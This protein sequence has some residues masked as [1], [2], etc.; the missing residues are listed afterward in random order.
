M[1]GME[2]TR[3]SVPSVGDEFDYARLGDERRTKRL[4]VIAERWSEAPDRSVLQASKSSAQAEGAYRFLN[5]DGFS[6]VPIVEAHAEQTYERIAHEQV[7]IV[8][9]DTTEVA[10]SGRV[11]REG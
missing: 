11:M 7:V 8:A 10:Y 4:Q 6:Y 5:N 1:E 9:H 2:K 3:L